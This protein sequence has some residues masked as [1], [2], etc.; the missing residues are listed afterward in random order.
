MR[1]LR[2]SPYLTSERKWILTPKSAK[3]LQQQHDLE[4]SQTGNLYF[5]TAATQ[6]NARIETSSNANTFGGRSA[7]G[8][9]LKVDCGIGADFVIGR[10]D[11]QNANSDRP[12]Q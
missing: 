12:G 8:G 11:G 9:T 1:R 6:V 4:F 3:L 5:A 10:M 2:V 7:N